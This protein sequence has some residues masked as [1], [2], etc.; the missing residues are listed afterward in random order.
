[1]LKWKNTPQAIHQG[2]ILRLH[3]VHGYL[4]LVFACMNAQTVWNAYE[5]LVWL[6]LFH[7]ILVTNSILE[8]LQCDT[9]TTERNMKKRR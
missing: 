6:C 3:S 9:L 1:M 7:N 2:N 8:L 4:R 5:K